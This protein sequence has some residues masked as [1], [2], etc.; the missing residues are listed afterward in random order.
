MARDNIDKA[1][2]EALDA[3]GKSGRSC[4]IVGSVCADGSGLPDQR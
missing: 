1:K 2:L 3:C 4:S